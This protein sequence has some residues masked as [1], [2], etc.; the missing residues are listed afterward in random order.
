MCGR[1]SFTTSKEKLK[2]QFG[3]IE[4]GD[5]LRINFNIAPTQHAYVVTND[6]PDRL[7]YITW[8]LIPHWSK[9]GKN[10]GKLINARMHLG[11][12]IPNK[13]RKKSMFSHGFA[14]RT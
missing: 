6:H 2:E 12:H 14:A 9:D 11:Q 1:F 7:Q 3:D 13:G 5:N 4:T 10:T 8:G